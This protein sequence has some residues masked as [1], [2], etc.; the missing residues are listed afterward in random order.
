[1]RQ[2]SQKRRRA[3][4]HDHLD[5]EQHIGMCLH[6]NGFQLRY[7]MSLGAYEHLVDMLHLLIDET[8]LSALTGN[9]TPITSRM[10][11]AVV[12]L[13]L[14]DKRV[15]SLADAFG[16]SIASV[17]LV[18]SKFLDAVDTCEDECIGFKLQISYED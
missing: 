4:R 14:R 2:Q 7:H 1:M 13:L 9:N 12:L 10:I 11:V 5:L 16:I 6:T 3:Y 17:K 8:R 15:K 18:V